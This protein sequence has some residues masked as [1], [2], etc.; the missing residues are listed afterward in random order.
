MTSNALAEAALMG[1]TAMQREAARQEGPVVVLAG[2]GTG[3][4][5]TLVA[6][7]VDRIVRRHI[8]AHRILAVTFTNKAADEM[9]TRI[10]AVLGLGAAPSWIGTFHGH[11][12]RQLRADPE[13]AV[14]RPGF[15]ICDAEDSRRIV[16][17]LLQRAADDGAWEPGDADTFRTRVRS[18]AQRI[19]LMKDNLVLPDQ[20]EAVL[21]SQIARFGANS[22]EDL[23]AWQLAAAL[24]P[25]YQAALREVNCADFGDLL[26]WPTVTML[27][28]EHYRLDWAR[29]FDAILAD[30][31]Q[32]V[33]RLQYLWLKLLSRDHGEFFAVGDD[34]QSIYSW[35]GASVGFI[36]DFQREFPSGRMIP[37]EQNFRSTGHILAA[38]NNVVAQ[39]RNRLGKTL[40]TEQGEG[41]PIET[42]AFSGGQQEAQ[43]LAREIGRRQLAGVALE[44]MAI[45]Y[46]YNFL[47]RML[48]EELLR[49]HIP[50]EL[51]NDTAFWQR[52]VVKDVLA[53]LR[54]AD[55]PDALQGDEAFRRVIN[56]P[57][58]G[59]GAKTL[60]RIE[61]LARDEALSLFVA[62][63]KIFADSQ[64]K[65]A[66]R[67]RAF[68]RI[69][70][71]EGGSVERALGARMRTLAERS[72]YLD[73]LRA[74]D[75]DGVA[76]L[77][78]LG[79]LFSLA[80]EFTSVEALFDHA[81]LGS[82][83]S[84]EAGRGR[85]RLMTIHGSKGLEFE[86]V[87]LMGW[88]STL[89]PGLSPTNLDEERRL[90]YVALTRGRARV[91][92]S[93]C[94]WRN[95]RSA[96]MSPFISD[97]PPEARY[98]GWLGQ[99]TSRAEALAIRA[100]QEEALGI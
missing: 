54:L 83:T 87:F 62:S 56:Q 61:Q 74:G 86:H 60:A 21:D 45:L 91:S 100:A 97:I 99:A 82:G 11:G 10:N 73:M 12:R 3:K 49:A 89:F 76:G 78:N 46:R 70:R 26:L 37:L 2:A 38:A 40:F 31:F 77:E 64:S 39:D 69:I 5:K 63:E 42:V 27:R 53:L 48:E 71:E 41:A 25:A 32:D 50:Y 55:S 92:V 6:G 43:G 4:T 65:T 8:P 30:E 84:A 28:D 47:S 57:A 79:E 1:L 24:Y 22:D 34:D 9:R 85:I 29:R 94:A 16:K 35:R 23:M 96:D 88:E 18:V 80:M 15:A 93:W 95:G 33:N 59:V 81:A 44:D 90:A 66:E 72:G 75:E 13:I 51:V 52:A 17:R 14:L 67:V 58:R 7:V 98:S 68:L 19:A 36:R 20:A